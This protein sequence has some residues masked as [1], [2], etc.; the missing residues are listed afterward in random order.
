MPGVYQAANGPTGSPPRT[1]PVF[2]SIF[3]PHTHKKNEA[4]LLFPMRKT[5]TAD[6]AETSHTDKDR[7]K[8]AW[9]LAS[10]KLARR[11]L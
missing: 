7:G 9:N 1:V 6:V 2:L 8:T 10:R 3:L 4:L 11:P 5:T